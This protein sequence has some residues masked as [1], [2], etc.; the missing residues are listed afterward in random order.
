MLFAVRV[1][2]G[3]C[4]LFGGCS[5]L[6]NGVGCCMITAVVWCLIVVGCCMLLGVCYVLYVVFRVLCV[7]CV[8]SFWCVARGAL[9]VVGWYA[10][11]AVCW[12]VSS[13]V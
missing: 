6:L 3:V 11:L 12:C 8:V 7:A 1:I 13:V 5:R 10:L 4:L 2:R 9:C